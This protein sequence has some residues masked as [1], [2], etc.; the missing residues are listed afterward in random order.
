MSRNILA[1][2]YTVMLW[3]LFI[4]LFSFILGTWNVPFIVFTALIILCL[5]L[6]IKNKRGL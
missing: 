3:L 1:T 5:A 6:I 2:F 4:F